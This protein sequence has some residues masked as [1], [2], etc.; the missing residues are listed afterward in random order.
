MPVDQDW[1]NVWPTAAT[2]KWSAV[3]FPVRQGFIKVS[4]FA[5]ND[6]LL[7]KIIYIYI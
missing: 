2:F 4:I 6:L 3:P 1:T 5:T 7:Y